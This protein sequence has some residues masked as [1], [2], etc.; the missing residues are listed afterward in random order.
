LKGI[1]P[2]F[3]DFLFTMML[4]CFTLKMTHPKPWWTILIFGCKE[5]TSPAKSPSSSPS[6]QRDKKRQVLKL[7]TA[8]IH[9]SILSTKIKK[10]IEKVQKHHENSMSKAWG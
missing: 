6:P 8:A 7:S 9:W 10:R 2:L 5:Q 4:R 3:V 1:E